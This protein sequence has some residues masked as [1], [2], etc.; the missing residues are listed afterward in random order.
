MLDATSNNIV[1]KK[2]VLEDRHAVSYWQ[3]LP[4]GSTSGNGRESNS[5]L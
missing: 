3:T 2:W 4:H 5:Q 1:D